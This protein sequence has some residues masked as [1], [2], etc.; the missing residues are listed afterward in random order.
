VARFSA[1]ERK[2]D[3]SREHRQPHRPSSIPSI[4]HDVLHRSGEPLNAADTDFAS[5][6]L[7]YDF[8][9]V[10]IHRDERAAQAAAAIGAS[11]YTYGSHVVFGNGQYQPAT[12]E[13]KRLLMHELTHV[14]QQSG[15]GADHSSPNGLD[16]PHGAAER[17]AVRSSAAA[18][19]GESA[20]GGEQIAPRTAAIQRQPETAKTGGTSS[21]PK[22]GA[23]AS[24]TT[25][26]SGTAPTGQQA[27]WTVSD[28]HLDFWI[29]KQV[30]WGASFRIANFSKATGPGFSTWSNPGIFNILPNEHVWLTS[31]YW[32]DNPEHPIPWDRYKPNLFNEIKF[33]PSG[34]GN[35]VHV[36]YDDDHPTYQGPGKA[37][38]VNLGS[39]S[40]APEAVGLP[41]YDLPLN[42]GGSLTWRAGFR[43]GGGGWSAGVE[44]TFRVESTAPPVSFGSG[45]TAP[46]TASTGTSPTGA[47]PAPDASG[48]KGQPLPAPPPSLPSQKSVDD[49][50]VREIQVYTEGVKKAQDAVSKD[51]LVGKLRDALSGIQPFLPA[52]EAQKMIDD[53]LRSLVKDGIDSGIMAILKA[54]TGKSPSTMP[55]GGSSSQIG[56]YPPSDVKGTQI[57]QGPKFTIPDT[58]KPAPRSS[59]QY[60][61]LRKSY[62]PGETI[63]ITV[64]PPQKSETLTGKRV[65]IVADADRDKVNPPALAGPTPVSD[66]DT[67]V[68]LKAPDT[69]G[70]YVIRINVGLNF[71]YSSVEEFEVKEAKK[72]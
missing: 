2:V 29:S 8:S 37:L 18:L 47:G 20:F 16:D 14:V 54:V 21:D 34:G 22:F 68:E 50:K 35:A 25:Q 40:S 62:T 19:A 30:G 69:A 26:G 43:F 39:K 48:K 23:T 51:A 24:N 58:A 72:Q 5:S 41:I 7:N 60:K 46:G 64:L 17:A 45:T 65:V 61:G 4:T 3:A 11:A 1:L 33:T 27:G 32:V 67:A 31:N 52:K 49:T 38:K 71:D 53:A 36:R 66:K 6:R 42:G 13:G 57:F 9:K 10:R 56:P 15:S 63:K 28:S 70:K 55:P 44:E 12:S 59:F